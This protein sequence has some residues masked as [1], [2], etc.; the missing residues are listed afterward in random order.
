MKRI[1][2][3]ATLALTSSAF[4]GCDSAKV[5]D[6]GKEGNEREQG[7]QNVEGEAIHSGNVLYLNSKKDL[8]KCEKKNF[9][10][11]YFVADTNKFLVCDQNGEYQ[12]VD[13]KGASGD[14]GDTG[15][16]GD[17]GDTG[18]K[19]DKGDTGDKGDKGDTGEKGDK[20]DTGEKGDKGNTG[21]KGDKGDQGNTGANGYNSLIKTTSLASGS[22][23]VYG[24]LKV[25]SGLDADRNHVLSAQETTDMALV[26]MENSKIQV[27]WTKLEVEQPLEMFMSDQQ[28]Q[29]S[30]HQDTH[31]SNF[32]LKIFGNRQLVHEFTSS[33]AGILSADPGIRTVD[34][35]N[36]VVV[37]S[38]SQPAA[39]QG[40]DASTPRKYLKIACSLNAGCVETLIRDGSFPGTLSSPNNASADVYFQIYVPGDGYYFFAGSDG[41]SISSL[42]W[43]SEDLTNLTTDSGAAASMLSDNIAAG[44]VGNSLVYFD[45]ERSGI[46]RVVNG[47]SSLIYTLPVDEFN[48]NQYWMI[49][50]SNNKSLF[51]GIATGNQNPIGSR[52]WYEVDKQTFVTTRVQLLPFSHGLY[53]DTYSNIEIDKWGRF[54]KNGFM[55]NPITG[56]KTN[57]V[58]SDLS[59]PT[60]ALQDIWVAHSKNGFT[61]MKQPDHS[62]RVLVGNHWR[63]QK[64]T[65]S[66]FD[67]TSGRV[68]SCGNGI[69]CVV[70]T[71]S[72]SLNI[73]GYS[74]RTLHYWNVT[75][76][77]TGNEA[78]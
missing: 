22:D 55:Y 26:C 63:D 31:G 27:E 61:V 6:S 1:F 72:A 34:T 7:S 3:L 35:A 32:K 20:G 14:K 4:F 67:G 58:P 40:I 21:D 66:G 50:E 68:M 56:V 41:Y 44:Q 53:R 23:C 49:K 12:E 57:T 65:T 39:N 64:I 16:K 54:F 78:N 15:D 11:V 5:S 77:F 19:G 45:H 17:K 74:S 75:G 76:Y 46:Y 51:Y 28:I 71:T 13:L 9:G 18:D 48:P 33:Y 37:L 36:L 52:Y 38:F 29:A 24:G 30:V 2:R 62:W 69:L 60:L 59:L 8:P 10:F 70:Q 43:V 42:Q 25:E 47:V 73:A